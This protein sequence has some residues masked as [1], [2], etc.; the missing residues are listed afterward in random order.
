MNPARPRAPTTRRP[1]DLGVNR[2]IKTVQESGLGHGSNVFAELGSTWFLLLSRPEEAAH[3]IG[4]LLLH[5]GEDNVIWGTDSIWYG[6]TQPVLDAFRAFQIPDDLCERFGYPK[7][8][9][10]MKRKILAGNAARV[11]GVDLDALAVAA[12]T[13]DLSWT[14]DVVAAYE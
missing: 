2:L 13:D 11:Y 1:R 3:T 12:A 10:E 5:L 7:L 4:K 8:T 9:A 6:P 14:N